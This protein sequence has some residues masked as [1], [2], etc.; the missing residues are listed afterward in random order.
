MDV[1]AALGRLNAATAGR[2]GELD[3]VRAG[4]GNLLGEPSQPEEVR[5]APAEVAKHAGAQL[6]AGT[7]A[8]VRDVLRLFE[9]SPWRAFSPSDVCPD[10]NALTP[11]GVRFFDLEGSGFWHALWDGAYARILFPTCWCAG[12]LPAG[13]PERLEAAYR[14]ELVEG[15]AEAADDE[16]F[17]AWMLRACAGW[18]LLST[19]WLLPWCLEKDPPLGYPNG[20]QPTTF[21]RSVT[22]RL[23]TFAELAEERPSLHAL[24][25]WAERIS[26][27][28]AERWP[29]EAF[30]LEPYP[31]FR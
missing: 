10:N 4:L 29:G 7:E 3:D 1:F 28:L 2:E 30:E 6:P 21:R 9:P 14:A 13:L 19:K 22:A 25:D 26:T 5:A 24:R 16:V 27:A 23:R 12:R 11:D 8:D 18:T 31:A 20:P 17:D 15:V